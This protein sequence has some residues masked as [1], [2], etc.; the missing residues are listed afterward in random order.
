LEARGLSPS[1]LAAKAENEKEIIG[2]NIQ[3]AF[4]AYTGYQGRIF[5]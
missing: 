2:Q 3:N 1:G 4:Q 5:A